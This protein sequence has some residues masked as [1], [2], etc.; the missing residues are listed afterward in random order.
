[1]NPE[2][3]SQ[4]DQAISFTRE[5]GLNCPEFILEPELEFNQE[6][7]ECLI[8]A[9]LDEV[10]VKSKLRIE[11][12]AM[13]CFWMSKD[14]KDFLKK[15]FDLNSVVTS[16]YL[17]S[18]GLTIY[19]ESKESIRERLTNPNHNSPIQFHTWVTLTNHLVLDL[20]L[21]PTMWFEGASKGIRTNKENAK[22]MAW[23]D[24]RIT[25]KKF[26]YYEPV[27]LGY[28]YFIK[29]NVR[30]RLQFFFEDDIR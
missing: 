28:D 22:K 3:L 16:G 9:I 29:A 2:Y 14:L 25:D 23:F 4:F 19:H 1:M 24:Y 18:S 26:A 15:R 8:N 11:D 5:M 30:P 6:D 10:Y 13:K 17:H 20:T 27:F 7:R 21:P 12:V